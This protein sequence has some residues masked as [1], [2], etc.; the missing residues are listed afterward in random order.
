MGRGYNLYC[1]PSS[2]LLSPPALW[3][4]RR[5]HGIGGSC[6]GGFQP[7]CLKG[8]WFPQWVPTLA[9]GC[10][11]AGSL[12]I[13]AVLRGGCPQRAYK[14]AAL[15]LSTNVFPSCLGC[16]W[17]APFSEVGAQEVQV[18]CPSLCTRRAPPPP[19]LE[20]VHVRDIENW[21]HGV[22]RSGR[23][24]FPGWEVGRCCLIKGRFVVL[25]RGQSEIFTQNS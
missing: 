24:S 2:I 8:Q 22:C 5:K 20:V 25:Q 12:S 14:S 10:G 19:L 15:C 6:A 17:A 1:H 13:L 4:E 9:T 3:A 7:R 11:G 18:T 16:T 21:L 23:G